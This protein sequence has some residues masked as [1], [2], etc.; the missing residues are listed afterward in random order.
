MN[1]RFGKSFTELSQ[2][3]DFICE[4]DSKKL[5]LESEQ[6][7]SKIK[8]NRQYDEIKSLRSGIEDYKKRIDNLAFL[9]SE[10]KAKDE[11]VEQLKLKIEKLERE[12]L[13]QSVENVKLNQ[14]ENEETFIP[15]VIFFLM[16]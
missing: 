12:V 11:E 1:Q 6:V 2:V 16:F 7:H 13:I 3:Q 15:K 8:Y 5:Q 10:V 9:Q 4:L 14:N